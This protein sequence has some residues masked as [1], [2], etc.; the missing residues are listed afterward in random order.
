MQEFT[1]IKKSKWGLRLIILNRRNFA[2]RKFANFLLYKL[3]CKSKDDILKVNFIIMNT[4]EII[5]TQNYLQH[6]FLIFRLISTNLDK[7]L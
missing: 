2:T 4:F 5:I 7:L 3:R 6:K 1:K